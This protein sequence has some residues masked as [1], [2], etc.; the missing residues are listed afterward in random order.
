MPSNIVDS[1]AK[2]TNKPKKEIERLWSKAKGIVEKQY[3]D[4]DPESSQYYA[5]TVGIL[6]K[7]L[8]V[9][10]SIRRLVRNIIEEQ[11]KGRF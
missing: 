11:V 5:L 10:E 9:K 3:P 6:K 7:M 1:Y 2:K 4:V 8:T